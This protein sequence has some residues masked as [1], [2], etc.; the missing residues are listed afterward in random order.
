MVLNFLKYFACQNNNAGGAVT[1]F[2]VLGASDVC[3][4][5][6]GRVNDVEELAGYQQAPF[7]G[8]KQTRTFMTVA[9]SLVMVCLPFWSTSNKSPP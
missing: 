6:G 5:A 9:P 8:T 7:V 1:H 4:D 3:E 2:G